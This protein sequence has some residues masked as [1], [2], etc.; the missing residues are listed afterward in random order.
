MY[1]WARIC[2]PF[3]SPGID[4]TLSYR[5]A[6]LHRLAESIRRNR[7]PGSINVY[8]YGLCIHRL[9]PRNSHP[10]PALASQD[11]RHLFVTPWEH[12]INGPRCV[13]KLSLINFAHF[14]KPIALLT[15]W[16]FP[17]LR[18]LNCVFPSLWECKLV[19]V[20]KMSSLGFQV[21]CSTVSDYTC[22]PQ[23]IIRQQVDSFKYS[24]LI[25]DGATGARDHGGHPFSQPA[26]GQLRVSLLRY[27]SLLK[28][29]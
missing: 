13:N 10:P 4:S 24:E 11:R 12:S 21:W 26:V 3:R 19:N 5:P 1:S 25:Q 17:L 7:F 2:S 9:R 23:F 22:F 18:V 6:R 16:S 15:N 27:V 8:K 20:I 29:M 14:S 28:N